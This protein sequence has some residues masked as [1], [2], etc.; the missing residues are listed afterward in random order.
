MSHMTKDGHNCSLRRKAGNLETAR[1][2]YESEL[3][4]DDDYYKNKP[5]FFAFPGVSNLGEHNLVTPPVV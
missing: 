3:G 1:A 4:S 5:S 2:L